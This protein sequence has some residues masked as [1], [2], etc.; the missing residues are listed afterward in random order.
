MDTNR[1]FSFTR[2]GYVMKR[3]WME[4][5]KTNLYTFLGI[6]LAYL[7]VYL[8]QMNGLN[9]S[10]AG[11]YY[12][13]DRLIGNYCS[14]FG[15]VFVF[16]MFVFATYIMNNMQ[17]KEARFSYLMLPAT[18]L[19]KFVSRALSVT[20][21]VVIM[22][23]LAS[24]LAEAVHWAFM[25]FFDEIP[26]RLKISVWPEAWGKVLETINPF[27][28]ETYQYCVDETTR[29]FVTRERS[30]FF[31]M[32]WAYWSVLWLHSL[33]ILGGSYYRKYAFFKT[34]GTL[35][36]VGIVLGRI[37]FL[38]NPAEIV[39]W[40]GEFVRRNEDWL[41]EEFAAGVMA[42]ITFCFTALNWWLSYKLFTRQQVI[43]PKF[44]L[45]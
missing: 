39:A 34:T 18:S 19:E 37:L 27:Q 45:L 33:Y 9:S 12:S 6:F 36:L 4:N 13:E 32:I 22:T 41:T 20:V 43:K 5:W 35:I 8:T 3:D 7:L 42:V 23:L 16:F 28:Q 14:S 24:L 26:D 40:F 21:G 15:A 11:Y 29:E 10:H 31:Q 25:P 30:I 44:R 2:L 17:T 1:Y 38:V